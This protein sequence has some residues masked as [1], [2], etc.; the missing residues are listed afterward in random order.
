M[1][2]PAANT[3]NTTTPTPT[4]DTTCGETTAPFSVKVSQPSGMFDGWFLRVV[5]DGILFTPSANS[6]SLFS[7]EASGHLCA[8]GYRGED[9]YPIIAIVGT[10]DS[11]GAVYL[12]DGNVTHRPGAA[13][14]RSTQ[15][16]RRPWPD[17]PRGLHGELGRLRHAA[18][19]GE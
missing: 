8:V 6:S 4:L 19:P 11:G 10:L 14:L 9:G 16:Y 18:G 15:V 3:T 5:T 13:R 12:I 7:V 17:L 2:C 1:A